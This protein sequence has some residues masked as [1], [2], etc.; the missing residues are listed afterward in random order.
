MNDMNDECQRAKASI[1]ETI[2]VE[3]LRL[4]IQQSCVSSWQLVHDFRQQKQLDPSKENVSKLL[5][6]M[7]EQLQ[8]TL[9]YIAEPNELLRELNSPDQVKDPSLRP[10]TA[11]LAVDLSGLTKKYE[12]DSAAFGTVLEI[13]KYEEL[14][15]HYAARAC[16][17]AKFTGQLCRKAFRNPTDMPE[18][19]VDRR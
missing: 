11:K 6:E 1:T 7:C 3:A 15:G 9:S 12:W 2:D 4:R 18:T 10:D 19:W 5:T 13:A 16:K 14:G 8:R 17:V